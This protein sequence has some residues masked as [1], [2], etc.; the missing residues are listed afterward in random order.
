[1]SLWGKQDNKTAGGTVS[2]AS[3]GYVTGTSTFFVTQATI[4]NTLKA[5]S[6][7]YQIVTITSNT[8]AKVIMGLNN[9]LGTVTTC[10]GEAY[11]LAEKPAFVSRESS[12]NS[13]ISGDSSFVYGVDT[14]EIKV[15]GYSLTDIAIIQSGTNYL[16]APTVTITQ[17]GGANTAAATATVSA[18]N[19]ISAI[20][21]TNAG[22]NLIRVPTINI[23]FPRRTITATQVTLATEIIGYGASG[24]TLH[25]LSNGAILAY[26][27]GG[28]ASMKDAGANIANA[29]IYYA[30]IASTSTFKLYNT[31]ANASIGGAN[32]LANISSQGT[33][34]QYFELQG[35]TKATATA[36]LGSG[37]SL[38][39]VSGEQ[40]VTHSGWVRRTI[41]T[42]GRAGRVTYETLVATGSIA[43]D[44][45]DDAKFP[46]AGV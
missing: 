18:A 9:G 33:N 6:I 14:G 39:E 37:D 1:M 17:S 29:T 32:G 26:N 40:Q 35:E 4:G 30:S 7:E 34:T 3:N 21:V 27:N 5:N 43:S 45:A 46:D 8:V 36:V 23:A 15:G 10:S 11:T 22:S 25:N 2:I 24:T 16:E 28:G 19:V 44:A 42:G 38:N 13:G 20:T 41:G 12:A 31:S